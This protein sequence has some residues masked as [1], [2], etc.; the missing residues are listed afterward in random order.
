MGAGVTPY[1]GVWIEIRK[2]GA[3]DMLHKVTP[4]MGVWIEIFLNSE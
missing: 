1:M 3:C 4:Y 2:Y